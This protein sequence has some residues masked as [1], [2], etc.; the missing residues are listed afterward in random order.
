VVE[1]SGILI[2]RYVHVY[3][4]VVMMNFRFKRSGGIAAKQAMENAG[5]TA[6]DIDVVILACSNMQ[7]AYPA[8]AIEIQSALGIK[9]M[10]MI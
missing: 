3:K 9:V 10:L 6:E 2:Q 7:R 4:N 1:K 5:V 8:V